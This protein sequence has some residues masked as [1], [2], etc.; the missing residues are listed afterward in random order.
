MGISTTG[1]VLTEN[2]DVFEILTTIEDTLKELI[3]KYSDGGHIFRDTSSFPVIEC[4]PR[5]GYFTLCFKVNNEDRMLSVHFDCDS[6]YS[7]YG[8]SK[9]IWS[10]N[11]WGMAEEIILSIC[12]VM[13]QYG[14]VFY[15]AN[16][17]D[18]DTIEV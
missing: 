2:K 12:E 15:E 6:D 3:R 9:I 14:K 8:D 10:V 16:D 7:E 17:F 18:G 4:S 5:M 11:W 1:F 13:K